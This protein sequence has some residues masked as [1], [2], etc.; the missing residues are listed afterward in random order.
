MFLAMSRVTTFIRRRHSA[1][2]SVKVSSS[3]KS[4]E[5]HLKANASSLNYIFQLAV[6][7]HKLG[8][9]WTIS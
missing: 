4:F 6:E 2:I 1:K 9:L 3:G 8:L 7:M 5:G